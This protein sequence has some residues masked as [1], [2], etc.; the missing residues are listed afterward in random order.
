[1]SVA[2]APAT[3]FATGSKA[4]RS[5]TFESQFSGLSLQD[6]AFFGAS[7]ASSSSQAE[8]AEFSIECQRHG[9]RVAKL[10][11]P[12]DQRKA[13]KRALVTEL[14]RHGAIKTTMARAKAIRGDVDHIITLAKDGS[15]HARRQAL[16]FVYDKNLVHSVFEKAP[17]RYAE[18]DGGYTRIQHTDPR[19]GD[20]S[21]MAVIE[22][23]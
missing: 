17:K 11:K 8:A 16:G 21:V 15:L 13:M 19:R 22:L 4:V 14:L 12:A 6:N 20:N 9:K 18:R 10:N 2:F 7:V 5:F 23:V 3:V 1:M